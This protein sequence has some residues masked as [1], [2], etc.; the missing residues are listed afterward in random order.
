MNCLYLNSFSLCMDLKILIPLFG[1]FITIFLG[2]L[3][4]PFIEKIKK[5]LERK[6]LLKALLAELNDEISIIDYAFSMLIDLYRTLYII[7]DTEKL[8]P[9]FNVYPGE[10]KLYSVDR[11]LEDHFENLNIDIRK[12]IKNIKEHIYFL[13]HLESELTEIYSFESEE[14]KLILKNNEVLRSHIGSYICIL[15][16]H[17]YNICYLIDLLNQKESKLK[18]YNKVEYAEAIEHQ[19]NELKEN[20]ILPLL[21]EHI[22]KRI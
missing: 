7:R 5:R 15:L 10:F 16:K 14:L 21:E 18:I 13:N 2:I 11:L 22:F 19:L 6:R 1:P 3:T 20:E 9:Y 8:I 12:T 4:I 17:R